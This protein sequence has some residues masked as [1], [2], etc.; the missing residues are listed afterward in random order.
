M[1]SCSALV[2]TD[3]DMNRPMWNLARIKYGLSHRDSVTREYC[4]GCFLDRG[5][6]EPSPCY[7]L[8][9]ALSP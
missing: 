4:H 6:D 3:A 8:L 9:G 5:T 7:G 2:F 1:F